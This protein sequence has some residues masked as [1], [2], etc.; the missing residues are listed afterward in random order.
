MQITFCKRLHNLIG[1]MLYGMIA[2]LVR[3]LLKNPD[4]DVV[5]L[6]IRA[7]RQRYVFPESEEQL[8]SQK[9]IIGCMMPLL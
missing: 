9:Y 1:G 6:H 3:L 5:G 8:N 2:C 4:E 7:P